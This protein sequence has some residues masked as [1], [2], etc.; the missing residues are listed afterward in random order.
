MVAK[1]FYLTNEGWNNEHDPDN[2]NLSAIGVYV[3]KGDDS[4]RNFTVRVWD[5]ENF[6]KHVEEHGASPKDIGIAVGSVKISHFYDE[7]AKTYKIG[8]KR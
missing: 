7:P 4:L 2:T 5:T 1:A 6:D 8:E 3:D